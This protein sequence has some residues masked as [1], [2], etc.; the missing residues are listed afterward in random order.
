MVISD[1]FISLSFMKVI[2]SRL[3]CISEPLFLASLSHA[4][5]SST[6]F[7]ISVPRETTLRSFTITKNRIGP[8]L[9]PWGKPAFTGQRFIKF[10]SLV[11]I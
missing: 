6:N 10:K 7:H 2:E 4:G 3:D 1:N 11:T 8:N 5:M 9:V